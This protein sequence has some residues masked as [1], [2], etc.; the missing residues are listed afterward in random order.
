MAEQTYQ[1][2]DSLIYTREQVRSWFQIRDDV[3]ENLKPV[4]KNRKL[5]TLNI[6]KAS[7]YIGAGL[8]MISEDSYYQAAKKEGYENG[9]FEFETDL[10]P[11]R[12]P[13]F[14]GDISASGLCTS[15]VALPSFYKLMTANVLFRA[16]STFSW[17]AATL[18]NA[19]VFSPIIRGMRG[20]VP[21]QT[22]EKFVEGNWPVMADVHPNTDLHL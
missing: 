13:Q 12:L 16:N 15:W 1:N 3:L 9:E 14:T 10:E 11:T 17:W 21:N 20:G 7:D 8:V 6:R 22:C 2:Q 18:G 4:L 19:K 5:V